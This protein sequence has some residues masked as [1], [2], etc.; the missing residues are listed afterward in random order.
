M[1]NSLFLFFII[2]NLSIK[3]QI[4]PSDSCNQGTYTMN[5]I[6]YPYTTSVLDST[7][8]TEGIYLCGP[9]TIVYDTLK[10]AGCRF[11]YINPGCTYITN[12][13]SC[14]I[15]DMYFIKDN[16]TLIIL[17]DANNSEFNIYHEPLATIL[18]STTGCQTVTPCS[19][20]IF[21]PINCSVG[22]VESTIQ[23][24]L[25]K[26]KPNPAS[27]NLTIEFNTNFQ[28]GE[29]EIYNMLGETM[30]STETNGQNTILNISDLS[31]GLYI[32]QVKSENKISRQRFIKH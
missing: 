14:A 6:F 9:N 27:D 26:T 19:A 32:V 7:Q 11:V 28:K 8:S 15:F 1:K 12:S 25:F 18:P 17:P 22:I 10:F 20:L 3:G 2:M 13:P 16:G 5:T 30:L 24:I 23:E 4:F 31:I 29:I 21:P